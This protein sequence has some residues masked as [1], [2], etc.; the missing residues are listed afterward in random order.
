MDAAKKLSFEVERIT[1]HQA[2][3]YLE[4]N[5]MNRPR[6]KATSR[7]Y[8]RQMLAGQWLMNAEAIKFDWNGDLVDGQHRLQA[9]Q[10]ANRPVE[11]LVVRGLD[12]EVFKTI[13]TGRVRKS[14]DL[15]ALRGIRNQFVFA[16]AFRLLY[17]FMIRDKSN[18]RISNTDLLEYVDKHPKLIEW[19]WEMM[20]NPYECRLITASFRV[21]FF[22]IA[23]HVNERK[24]RS[25]MEAF[26]AGK[27]SKSAPGRLHYRLREVMAEVVPPPAKVRHAWLLLAWNAYLN[28]DVPQRLSRTLDEIPDFSPRP[29]IQ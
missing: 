26:A 6:S 15:L 13:D 24:A 16:A 10:I 4:R 9:I 8:A 18:H 29:R 21:Y 17:R 1:P 12:P 7:E 3:K 11:M 28:D 27:D 5:R 22:Y 19:G 2:G 25:F 23:A 20:R 14:A